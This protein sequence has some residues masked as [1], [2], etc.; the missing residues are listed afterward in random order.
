MRRPNPLRSGSVATPWLTVLAFLA[1]AALA[2]GC[3]DFLEPEE[4]EPRTGELRVD[5]LVRDTGRTAVEIE[6][7][8]LRARGDDG[9]LAPV[10]DSALRLFGRAL[11]PDSV[12]DGE[13]F[14]YRAE[15]TLTADERELPAVEFEGPAAGAD[16]TRA[17]LTLPL[18][19]Q[20]GPDTVALEEGRDLR[21]PLDPGSPD[22]YGNVGTLAWT[23]VVS[24]A[25]GRSLLIMKGTG[26]PPDTL[27]VA[28]S[29]LDQEEGSSAGD[30]GDPV[31]AEF[32]IDMNARRSPPGLPH[33]L[34]LDATVAVAWGLR[35]E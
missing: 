3:I 2:G 32:W 28:R 1:S 33:H 27:R 20:A 29:L 19:D 22:A 34:V 25:S 12:G 11:P 15:W 30:P 5:L 9:R 13:V 16:G 31:R 14:R 4:L 18:I 24:G 21:L 17:R 10:T 8:L 26:R 7:R 6:G 23:L 35:P